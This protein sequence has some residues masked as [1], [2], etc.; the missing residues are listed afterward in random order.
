MYFLFSTG[1]R[2]CSLDT[3]TLFKSELMSKSQ[4]YLPPEA[5]Y[6]CVAE[7]GELGTKCRFFFVTNNAVF[8]VLFSLLTSTLMSQ[9]SNAIS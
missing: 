5:A 4:L 2:V 3:M 7:L 6:N 8:Q 1:G 9:R